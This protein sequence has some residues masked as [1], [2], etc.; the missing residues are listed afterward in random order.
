M[1]A[2]ETHQLRQFFG[3]DGVGEKCRLYLPTFSGPVKVETGSSGPVQTA[4]PARSTA[5]RYPGHTFADRDAKAAFYVTSILSRAV[6]SDNIQWEDAGTYAPGQSGTAFVFGSRSNQAA[7]WVTADSAFGRFFRFEFG[8][9]WS[10]RAGDRVFSLPAPDRLTREEY[11]QETDYGVIGR[12]LG[13]ATEGQLFLIAGLGSR[14]TE[15][16]AYYL[17]REWENLARRFWGKDFAVIL[18]F[19]PPINP[20]QSEE[21]AAFD[22]T[23]EG[24]PGG[25]TSP[26]APR[27][28]RGRVRRRGRGTAGG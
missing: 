23:T 7:E 15:G 11:E 28:A 12:L 20:R 26:A 3:L 14:A 10:I 25:G 18:K 5:L 24:R 8:R 9:E 21:V 2:T 6:E 13:S 17:T 22:D 1:T 19:P 4:K 27:P 16:C